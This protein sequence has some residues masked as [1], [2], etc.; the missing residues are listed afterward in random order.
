M[1]IDLMPINEAGKKQIEVAM[2]SAFR[3]TP[4]LS[5]VEIAE[6]D[7]ILSP[8]YSKLTGRPN[9][10]LYPYLREPINRLSPDDPCRVMTFEGPV[11][12][13]KSMIGQA[14]VVAVIGYWPG[15]MLWATSHDTKAEEFS[16]NRLDLMI[17]DSALLSRLVSSDVKSKANTIKLKRFPGGTLKLVGAQSVSGLTSD[18]V[19]YAFVDESDDHRVN[20]SGAGSSIELIRNRMTT[21]GDLSK[22]AIVSS[23][24]IDG[25]S[26][27]DAWRR[28]G[29]DRRYLVPCPFCGEMIEL[30][31]CDDELKNWRLVW[32]KGQYDDIGYICQSCGG[33]IREHQKNAMNRAGRWSEPMN[34]AADGTNESYSLNFLY[35]PP[36]TYTWCDF[37]RQW[38]AAVDRLGAGDLDP[39]HTLVNTRLARTWRDRGETM[40]K[41]ALAARLEGDFDVLPAGVQYITMATDVQRDRLETM[42]VGWG[43][44]LEAWILDYDVTHGDTDD[45]ATWAEMDRL[46]SRKFRPFEGS[47]RQ[48]DIALIDRGFA[49]DRVLAYTTPRAR[50]KTYAIKGVAGLPKDPIWDKKP[51]RSKAKKLKHAPYYIVR[52]TAAKDFASSMLTITTHGP[53]Y[54]HIQRRLVQE[55]PDFL[56]QMASERRVRQ[57]DRAGRVVVRWETLT[58]A[59][60][61]EV[62]DTF[63]YNVAAINALLLSGKELKP[64]D[65]PRPAPLSAADEAAVVAEIFEKPAVAVQSI[66]RVARPRG[67]W[68]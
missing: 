59:T 7:L 50:S 37:A 42:W 20:V 49:A 51:A 63:C 13:G 4:H 60:R 17:R 46:R 8:E 12:C 11:Q 62:W 35:L 41:S 66:R 57:R 21:Y 31:A 68:R 56:D 65:L 15:P 58:D 19:R 43:E 29:T 47:A 24:S 44:G 3:P 14:F 32:Q 39:M 40:D 33:K 10:D 16:K 6:R 23:P 22:M 54:V 30:Q 26:E 18:T 67:R 25:A 1:S 36:G 38:D 61:N 28:A 53:K 55:F 45:P 52:T 48:A 27:I 2:R 5:V 64:L 34:R 9:F